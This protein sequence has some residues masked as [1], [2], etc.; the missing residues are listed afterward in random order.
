MS[1]PPKD[2]RGE[3]FG[4]LAPLKQVST[5]PVMWECRCSCGEIVTAT[6][7][8]L[9]RTL[10]ACPACRQAYK[11][12]VKPAYLMTKNPAASSWYTMIKRC[13]D[14]AYR[15]YPNF[16]G[17]GIKI[18]PPWMELDKFMEDM[19]QR[20]ENHVLHRRDS[21]GDFTPANCLWV[22]KKVSYAT[23]GTMIT[24]NGVT[25]S[26]AAWARSVGITA[27]ALIGRLDRG[28]A[29]EKA[30]TVTKNDIPM[31]D[32]FCPKPHSWPGPCPCTIPCPDPDYSHFT[33]AKVTE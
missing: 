18:H 30:L 15:E 25:R 23:R 32:Y 26:T 1:R 14:P 10:R 4:W 21:E 28:W 3:V 2:L 13:T 29:L 12:H 31:D 7:Q 33:S 24:F 20:P 19:G 22:P 6:P 16:G 17:S 8:H 27:Q 9:K 11:R 5:N